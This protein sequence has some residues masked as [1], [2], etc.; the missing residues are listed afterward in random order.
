[1]IGA[2]QSSPSIMFTILGS[3]STVFMEGFLMVWKNTSG[4][5]ADMLVTALDNS[6]ASVFF[7][8]FDILDYESLEIV[9]HPLD[10][11]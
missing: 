11:G 9:I 4:C 6:S 10:G 2:R 3:G 7:C 8:P 1:M 5:N